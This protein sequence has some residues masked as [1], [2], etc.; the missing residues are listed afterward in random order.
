MTQELDPPVTAHLDA[1]GHSALDVAFPWMFSAFVGYLSP[2]ET[3]LLWDRIIGFDSLLV[4][5]VLAVAVM[6]FRCVCVLCY[7]RRHFQPSR[8]SMTLSIYLNSVLVQ[9]SFKLKPLAK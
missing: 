9:T 3:L 7:S 2:S 5:P 4:L 6:T 8:M 1:L